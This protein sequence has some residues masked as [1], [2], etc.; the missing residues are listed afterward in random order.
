MKINWKHTMVALVLTASLVISSASFHAAADEKYTQTSVE[1]TYQLTDAI[2]VEVKGILNES[3]SEG[4]RIAATIRL[5][6]NGDRLTG[7]PEYEVRVKTQEGLEYIM[8]PSQA[9]A[10]NIQPKETVE[11]SY[12]NV[13][14]RY[15]NF[16]LT[17][18]SWLDVNEFVYPKQE[19]R[20]ISIP[21]SSNE[22]KGEKATL[23]NPAVTKKWEDTFTIP[24]LSTTLEFK[25]V[26]LNE[27]NT[28]DGP[29]VIV[30]LLV[31]NQGDKKTTIPDFRINGISDKKVYNGK[32][33]EQGPL[34]LEYG[35]QTYIHYAIPAR[36]RLEMK[37]L[38]ILTPEDFAGEDKTHTNYLIGRLTITLPGAK[39][40]IGY[41][42]QLS[43]Y[44]W[45][46]P[47]HFDPLYKLI[48]PEVDVSMVDLRLQ[49]SAGGG[50]KAAV[51]KFKLLNHSDTPMQV[52]QFD[53]KLTS[54]NGNS[55][56]GTRQNTQVDTLIPNISYV[57]YYSFI[58]PSSETGEQLVME[59]LDGKSVAPYHITMA[60]FK[61]KVMDTKEDST[62][63][64][65]P[66]QATLN[67]W[68]TSANYN[69]G[70]GLPYS[71]KLNLDFT[72][73]LQDEVVVDQSFSK[74]RL[75]LVDAKERIMVSKVLSFT[76]E[77]KLVSGAQTINFDLDRFETTVFLRMYEIIDTPF[78]EARRLIQTWKR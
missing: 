64:F 27:Q 73:K 69:N 22:W 42:N 33:L 77:N 25:P 61:T 51:A 11:L 10:K 29:M 39:S 74:M 70:N 55:Y 36:N 71:Y 43:P 21:I 28:P 19:E 56:M 49:E 15:D 47:I 58:I 23:A 76:G 68:S 54:Y 72:I 44:E 37:S 53:T 18:L 26:S 31:T 40:T 32:R 9:N 20:I 16:S 6:N 13:I 34:S 1:K 67:D 24:V 45:N 41:I 60:A 5:F 78:G 66:F 2:K 35:E 46:K 38:S 75:E 50:F 65:Y 57:I 17:E 7:V 63:A 52:P 30:G 12:M 8:R 14:D 62:L 4:T 59:I 3:T 48:R